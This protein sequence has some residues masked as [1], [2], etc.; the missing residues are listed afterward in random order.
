M[1]YSTQGC[2]QDFPICTLVCFQS[3]I[4][5]RDLSTS[6]AL[7]SGS[8]VAG[9]NRQK[10]HG[11]TWHCSCPSNLGHSSSTSIS[12]SALYRS[13]SVPKPDDQVINDGL[14]KS[15]GLACRSNK[16]ACGGNIFQCLTSPSQADNQCSGCQCLMSCVS[17]TVSVTV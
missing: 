13:I 15:G 5:S 6:P 16:G 4:Y 8:I 9:F 17:L 7:G 1:T 11:Q 10:L 3:I 14:V 12:T 2:H